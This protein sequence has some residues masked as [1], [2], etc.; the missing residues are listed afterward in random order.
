M[1]LSEEPSG[2]RQKKVYRVSFMVKSILNDFQKIALSEFVKTSLAQKYYLSGGTALAE[3]YLHHRR[4]EDLDFFTNHELDLDELKRFIQ[5]LSHKIDIKQIEFQKGFG[6]YTFFLNEN[7]SGLKYK[8]DFGQYPF[9]PIEKLKQI[10]S[11]NIESLFDIAVNKAH[12]IAFRPRLRDFIDIYFI[13][14]QNRDWT[15]PELFHRSFEKFEM[16]ADSL[17]IGQ[18]LIQVQILKDMPIMLIPF[19]MEDIK[20]FFLK[21][22]RKLEKEIW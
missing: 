8:I 12:T 2:S 22:A 3:F 10:Q 16:R 5:K 6:L 13:L 21:E 9:A 4:S 15:L 17:Q 14:E 1:E 20:N 11:L 19:K 7:N 18:N